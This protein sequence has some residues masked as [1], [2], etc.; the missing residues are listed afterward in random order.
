M[1]S[2]YESIMDVDDKIE[3]MDFAISSMNK[4]DVKSIILIIFDEKDL[5]N[6]KNIK[7]VFGNVNTHIFNNDIDINI[8]H[9]NVSIL[10]HHWTPLDIN[11]ES[12]KIIYTI[13]ERCC[14]ELLYARE[15]HKGMVNIYMND[16]IK[17]AFN[18]SDH[19]FSYWRQ[20]KAFSIVFSPRKGNFKVR[21]TCSAQT[22]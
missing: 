19:N 5:T 12:T 16:W 10:D 9:K 18:G 6:D 4:L 13:A 21:L 17:K 3:N 14:K 20:S 2:L 8:F 1:K 22:R 15:N 7:Q 11:N